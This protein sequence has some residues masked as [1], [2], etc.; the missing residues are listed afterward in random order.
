MDLRPPHKLPEWGIIQSSWMPRA[1]LPCSVALI[2]LFYFILF[3]EQSRRWS[4]ATL[5]VAPV[6]DAACVHD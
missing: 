1:Q 5:L 4:A 2:V 6:F 3:H